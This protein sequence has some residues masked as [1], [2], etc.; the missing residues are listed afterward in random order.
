MAFHIKGD[1]ITTCS[2]Q[3]ICPCPIDGPPSGKDGH[4][5]GAGVFHITEGNLDDT[6]LSGVSVGMIYHAPG[7]F[8]GGNINMGIILDPSVSDEQTAAAEKIFKGEVGGPFAQ[9]VPLIGNWLGTERAPV[10]VELGKS[11]SATIGDN[12]INVEVAIGPD[13]NPTVIKN[14]AQAWRA[15]GYQPG[16]GSGTFS[17]MGV[18]Y[19]SIHG[20]HS[21]FEF[22]S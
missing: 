11:M 3:L 8:S 13:G 17:L 14:A 16:K 1:W 5:R 4:C 19:E 7:N 2:C 21:E 20:E 9:F 10:N 18:E 15:E 22:T 6:D 12:T